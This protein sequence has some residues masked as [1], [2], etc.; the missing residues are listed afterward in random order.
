[1]NNQGNTILP[2]ELPVTDPKRNETYE[3]F[4]NKI[5]I[6]ILK[7]LS[8]L[9]E[10][11]NTQLNKISKTMHEQNRVFNRDSNQNKIL[12]SV[13]KKHNDRNE[14]SQGTTTAH[15]IKQKK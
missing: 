3:I 13:A 7:E 8:E 1:M 14:K 11:T 2:K 10:H 15:S 5:K 4:N 12:L 9:Q 6:I